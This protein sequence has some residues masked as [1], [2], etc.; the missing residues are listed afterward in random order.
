MNIKA[1]LTIL[2]L[3]ISAGAFSQSVGINSDGSTPNS[4]AILDISSVNQGLLIPRI[5]LAGINDVATIAIPAASLLVYNL[6]SGH[7]LTPGF[8]YNAGTTAIAAWTRIS[9]TVVQ[10]M[11]GPAGPQGIQGATG[12]T[13]PVGATG[14]AGLTGIAG[15]DGA[16]GEQGPVGPIG[17]EGMQGD[18]GDKGDKGQEGATGPTG[19][20]GS[21]AANVLTGVVA[22][23]N[24]GTNS[25]ATPVSG[26][27]AYGDSSGKILFTAAGT[28]GQ[29][30]ASAGAGIPTWSNAS[31]LAVPYTGATKAVNLGNYDLA[32]NTLTI[33]LGGSS[34]G[35]NTATGFQS[36]MANTNGNNNTAN[37]NNTLR[38]NTTGNQNTAIGSSSLSSIISGI[39]NTAAGYAAL[40]SAT[41]GY[42]NTA[43]GALTLPYT[44]TGGFN[45]ANGD[46][47]LLSNTTGNYNTAS[48][49]D[50]LQTNSTGNNNTGIGTSADVSSGDLSNATA[51]GSGAIVSASNSV[52]LGNA[53]VTVIGGQVG[54]T[55]ASDIRLKK[56]ITNTKYG[57]ATVMKLRAVDYNLISNDLRQ[58]GFIAQEVKK[59]V[60]E[61]ITGKEG[62]IKKGET[63]GITYAN[64]VPVLSRAIQEQQAQISSQQKEID[65]LKKMVEQLL[66]KK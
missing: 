40:M 38:A 17:P 26:G 58:V 19:A 35:T 18:K 6:T 46:Q 56:N 59:L 48:G 39:A 61:V 11:V 60:P 9:D 29:I 34:V 54:W 20:T 4:S 13:G 52:R 22:V 23:A 14:P 7:G 41:T 32:V 42:A 27:V 28:T 55:A 21:S 10:G 37:G 24:G 2:A 44:S 25:S 57:L 12:A 50:A 16:A 33:G 30:L 5:S 51:I 36:L 31:A 49:F 8:Y 45:T 64:L 63:L 66:N 65:A 53:N 62:D 43:N 15:K 3:I 47:S 1:L